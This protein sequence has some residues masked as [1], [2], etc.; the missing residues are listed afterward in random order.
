MNKRYKKTDVFGGVMLSIAMILLYVPA[1]GVVLSLC[2]LG[3]LGYGFFKLSFW[4]APV[5]YD[6]LM[7]GIAYVS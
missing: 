5:L 2:M 1:V 7:Q 4:L 3:L 6:L